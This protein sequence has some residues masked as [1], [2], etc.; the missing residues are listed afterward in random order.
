MKQPRLLALL[1]VV[2]LA[3]VLIVFLALRD[4]SDADLAGSSDSFAFLGTFQD[5]PI[6]W[7]ECGAIAWT[8]NPG[9]ASDEIVA[10]IE[11]GIN[12]IGQ[13]SGFEFVF[14]GETAETRPDG[15]RSN[16]TAQGIHIEIVDDSES[17][18]LEVGEF[19]KTDARFEDGIITGAVIALDAD[20]I[21]S[22]GTGFGPLTW[23]SLIG[24]E[25]GHALGLDHTENPTDLLFR[26]WA[27]GDGVPSA[28]DVAGLE[29]L[30]AEHPC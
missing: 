17:Q 19:G 28:G 3:L 10:S 16:P 14:L 7:S 26:D 6:T 29:I 23:E 2:G 12:E 4:G 11:S 5:R 15:M 18:L 30:R 27:L 21:G 1:A 20:N 25:L 8:I 22:L 13:L 24:H 9:P